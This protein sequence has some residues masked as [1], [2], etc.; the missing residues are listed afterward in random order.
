[1]PVIPSSLTPNQPSYSNSVYASSTYTASAGT[2]RAPNLPS[3]AI[4]PIRTVSLRTRRPEEFPVQPFQP[5]DARNSPPPLYTSRA[6]E[7]DRPIRATEGDRRSLGSLQSGSSFSGTADRSIDSNGDSLGP[8]ANFI[9]RSGSEP[10][11]GSNG[12]TSSLDFD[13]RSLNALPVV[14]E[15]LSPAPTPSSARADPSQLPNVVSLD[16]WASEAT[17]PTSRGDRPGFIPPRRPPHTLHTS[18]PVIPSRDVSLPK[19]TAD[20]YTDQGIALL[21]PHASGKHDA[22]E[23]MRRFRAAH[24]LASRA[25]DLFRE[26]R[27]LCNEGVALLQKPGKE[28]EA[29]LRLRE[30]WDMLRRCVLRS[31]TRTYWTELVDSMLDEWEEEISPTA[32]DEDEAV[33]TTQAKSR[34]RKKAQK[35]LLRISGSAAYKKTGG[36]L[37]AADPVTGPPIAA[38]LMDLM[39][40]LG[41]AT[42][43]LPG[44]WVEAI[45]WWEG[46]IELAD[47][48]WGRY[49]VPDPTSTTGKPFKLTYIHRH[50][51]IGRIKAWTH[52]GYALGIQGHFEEAVGCH[53]RANEM[54]DHLDKLVRNWA[55]SLGV[56]LPSLG[57]VGG[58]HGPPRT[59]SAMMNLPNRTASVASVLSAGSATTLV[60]PPQREMAELPTLR[61]L[62]ST[63][64]QLRGVA[65]S[66]LATAFQG[67]GMYKQAVVLRRAALAEFQKCGDVL[68]VG[69][70]RMNVA[71]LLVEWGRAAAGIAHEEEEL[72]IVLEAPGRP[73]TPGA[74]ELLTE[75]G[76][77]L[78]VLGTGALL[79]QMPLY[80]VEPQGATVPFP[81]VHKNKIAEA[82][83][84]DG[85]LGAVAP[86]LDVLMLP[87]VSLKYLDRL[88]RNSLAS[89][90]RLALDSVDL[91]N[92]QPKPEAEFP[93]LWTSRS[94]LTV[95][96]AAVQLL[97]R[98]PMMAGPAAAPRGFEGLLAKLR[99][100]SELA[101]SFPP[102]HREAGLRLLSHLIKGMK[103]LM[104]DDTILVVE[105]SGA[106]VADQ[107]TSIL[108]DKRK[109]RQAD[110]V[111]RASGRLQH[112]DRKGAGTSASLAPGSLRVATKPPARPLDE[113]RMLN[114][115]ETARAMLLGA[116][117]LFTWISD[118]EPAPQWERDLR[119]GW[120]KE[121]LAMLSSV[122]WELVEASEGRVKDWPARFGSLQRPK[123]HASGS[124]AG[125]DSASGPPRS[126]SRYP[127]AGSSDAMLAEEGAMTLT[128]RLVNL[129]QL[130]LKDL[131]EN[132]PD[133]QTPV[134]IP[135]SPPTPSASL[136]SD[137]AWVRA[138]VRLPFMPTAVLVRILESVAELA[139]IRYPESLFSDSDLGPDPRTNLET[140]LSP[141]SRKLIRSAARMLSLRHVLGSCRTCLAALCARL[142]TPVEGNSPTPTSA[143]GMA[144]GSGNGKEAPSPPPGSQPNPP[145]LPRHSSLGMKPFDMASS[146]ASTSPT[147]GLART[148]TLS[149]ARRRFERSDDRVAALLAD[150]GSVCSHVDLRGA[151][152]T[153]MP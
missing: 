75:A 15:L 53:N 11:L 78:A 127:E 47:R 139:A 18:R 130:W 102:Q 126:T 67:L 112:E 42:L 2:L 57:A 66:H 133:A 70:E 30:S 87:G 59:S 117:G 116:A 110:M 21:T 24:E 76:E 104:E 88:M 6:S 96:S 52:I 98:Q 90:R 51:L 37:M 74:A 128:E 82:V 94:L 33:T 115:V 12:S 3:N 17:Q 79:D 72:A 36:G 13:R 85:L 119:A 103:E 8:L 10:L 100:P 134:E 56:P 140:P 148:K 58:W 152:W 137:S 97:D 44:K 131:G 50:T 48:V 62:V 123:A 1:M 22:D 147:V 122:V 16:T 141:E 73:R 84:V 101:T 25:A 120:A 132:M 143:S 118:D 149:V 40:N 106:V 39:I 64:A 150:L 61:Y 34:A 145:L 19:F 80:N 77:T 32:T 91:M 125:P 99:L 89:V 81:V 27:A 142:A 108:S 65:G 86:A 28:A 35:E 31:K 4:H 124:G 129:C 38:F 43:R 93:T 20:E 26:S 68:G 111:S 144:S 136:P 71:A 95:F 69:R 7:D 46:A 49:P 9:P 55:T 109:L 41:N 153:G 151:A 135:T 83:S 105:D 138:G 114:F 45:G 121:G 14:D 92:R 29:W 54:L 113:T 107:N 5:L 146:S 23:A 63:I 60:N